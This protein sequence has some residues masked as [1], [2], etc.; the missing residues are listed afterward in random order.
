MYYEGEITLS[1]NLLEGPIPPD[2]AKLSELGT[3]RSFCAPVVSIPLRYYLTGFSCT[4]TFI[5]SFNLFKGEIPDFMWK[6]EDMGKKILRR[7]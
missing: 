3:W 2:Y 4:D 7:L 5:L 1:D 6:Y